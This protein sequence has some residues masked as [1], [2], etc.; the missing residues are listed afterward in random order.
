MMTGTV[1]ITGAGRGLGRSLAER[2]AAAGWTV[3][4][5]LRDPAARAGLDSRIRPHLMDVTDRALRTRLA[6]DLAD[7][8]LDLLINNAG[9]YGPREQ[10]LG[11]IDEAAWDEAFRVNCMAPYFMA[12][13]LLPALARARGKVVTV[14]SIMG[15]IGQARG[16]GYIYRS[17]KAAANMAMKLFAGDVAG[18]G[19]TAVTIHPGWV[20]TAMGGPSAALS[21]EESTAALHRTIS[22]LTVRD[23]AKFLNM[24]GEVLPW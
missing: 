19:I 9:V 20:R 21:I 4:A 5:V 24:D 2:Y 22:K 16:G 18:Q 17:T 1:L 14:T 8:A 23:N 10:R 6:G 13:A 15:S 3:H 12:E 11:D 7:T